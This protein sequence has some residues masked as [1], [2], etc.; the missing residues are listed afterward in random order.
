MHSREGVVFI[1]RHAAE[2][3]FLYLAYNAVHSPYETA[4]ESY[5]ERVSYILTRTGKYYAAMVA[6]LDDG[7]GQVLKRT[8]PKPSGK[9]IGLFP[10]R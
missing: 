2:P 6:A 3:F 9:H 5:L 1:N 7:V 10:E 8:R 4:P